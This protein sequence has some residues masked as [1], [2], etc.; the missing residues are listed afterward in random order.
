MNCRSFIMA[1]SFGLSTAFLAGTS[2]QAAISCNGAGDRWHTQGLHLSAGGGN[3][4]S[5]GDLEVGRH[6]P[7]L[8]RA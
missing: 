8:A 3:R 7:S 5:S 1:V 2:A 6:K 4:S